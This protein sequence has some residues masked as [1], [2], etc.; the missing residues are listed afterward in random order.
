MDGNFEALGCWVLIEVEGNRV[1]NFV[2]LGHVRHNQVAPPHYLG[3]GCAI[4][5]PALPHLL[6]FYVLVGQ[7]VQ[8]QGVTGALQSRHEHFN[9]HV[10]PLGVAGFGG[11]VLDAGWLVEALP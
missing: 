8:L 7:Q 6:H 9:E 2:E 5:A 1:E 3:V 11:D 4:Y 10:E